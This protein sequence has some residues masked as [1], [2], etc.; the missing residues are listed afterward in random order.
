[1]LMHYQLEKKA[2]DIMFSSKI[3]IYLCMIIGYISEESILWCYCSQAF[4]TEKV[5][6]R[7]I[8]DYF[9]VN[10]KQRSNTRKLKYVIYKNFERKLKSPFTIHMQIL[11]T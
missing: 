1:M 8:K 6:K 9:K 7:Q 11:K 4:S 5:L 2:K 3:L 10:G